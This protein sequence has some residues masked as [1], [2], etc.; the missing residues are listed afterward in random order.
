MKTSIPRTT[1]AAH[2]YTVDL[3]DGKYRIIVHVNGSLNC[4]RYGEEWRNL[5]G[6]K[7]VLALVHEIRRLREQCAAIQS[8][9]PTSEEKT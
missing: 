3:E 5:T 8:A 9:R 2:E 6:D 4:F 1:T 7:M